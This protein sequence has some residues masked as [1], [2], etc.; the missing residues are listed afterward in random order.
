MIIPI[1]HDQSIRRWPWVTGAIVAICTLVQIWA[2]IDPQAHV[3][4]RFGYQTGSGLNLQLV[5]STFV[6]AGWIHLVG[7]MLFLVLACSVLEDRWGRAKF[8]VFYVVGG[9]A[10]TFA[11]DALYHGEGTLLVGASGA[12]SAAMGAFLVYYASTEITFWYWLMMRTGTFR[13]AAYLALPL[14]LLE[15]FLEMKLSPSTGVESV[16]YS[17]HIGGFT[18]GV[19]TALVGNMVFGRRDHDGEVAAQEP[20]FYRDR[21]AKLV[22]AIHRGDPDVR[23]LASRMVLVLSRAGNHAMIARLC[24]EMGAKLALTEPAYVAA[25]AAADP[26]LY[27]AVVAALDRDMPRSSQLPELMWRTVQL[28]RDARRTDEMFAT[29]E[30]IAARFPDTPFGIKAAALLEQQAARTTL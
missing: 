6:H 4:A 9:V 24:G 15:Q 2:Q 10:A 22:R 18:F 13:M 29:L 1:G 28:H 30:A 16:A 25:A 23:A 19:A 8:A 20:A 21:Y 17:A 11:F 14:W 26:K 12:I 3:L 5:T 27:L 7:N